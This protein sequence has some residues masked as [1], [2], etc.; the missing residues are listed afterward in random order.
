MIADLARYAARQAMLGLVGIGQQALGGL[1]G[2]GATGGIAAGF[3]GSGPLYAD[4]GYTGNGAKH[5]PA[6]IVHKGEYVFSKAATSRMGV[7]TLEAMHQSAVRGYADGGF[8]GR[9]AS[10]LAT[11]VNDAGGRAAGPAAPLKVTIN[12]NAPG[13]DVSAQQSPDGGV[14]I[15]IR[16]MVRGEMQSAFEDGAFD[17]VGA[18]RFG[19]RRVMS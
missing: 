17:R 13:V 16:K 6:G 15:D 9:E 19:W 3:A 12:N 8:V 11:Y 2:G 14:Q 10:R 4:G 5:E 18:R 1:F 7:R